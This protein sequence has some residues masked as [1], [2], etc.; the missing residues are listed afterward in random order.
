VRDPEPFGRRRFLARAAAGASLFALAGCDRLSQRPWFT[1]ILDSA[2]VVTRHVQG[3]V[4]RR[5]ALAPE[6]TEADLSTDFRANGTTDPGDADYQKLVDNGFADWRL[7]VGGMVEHPQSFS[8]AEL[9]QLPSRTQI[10]R[11]DCV[12][13]WSCIAKWKGVAL[14]ALLDE[15]WP[16]PGARY[17]M[18]FCADPMEQT[19]DGTDSRYYESIDLAGARH[20]QTILAYEMNDQALPIP[21]GAP[22]RLRDERQLGYKMAKYIMRIALVD[23]FAN[24]RGGRGGY[25]EDRG[26]EWYAGI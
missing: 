17:V 7:A 15:V 24:I 4:T 2:E 9:R 20:P 19:L 1:R 16:L 11:H 13:G 6:Y 22:L 5:Q 25:W 26:Y 8:L 12:E 23:S 21:H 18:F 10:T 3:L 14:S